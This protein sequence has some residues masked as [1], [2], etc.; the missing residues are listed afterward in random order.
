M[1][2]LG[3][4]NAFVQAAEAE[5]SRS[6]D[7]NSACRRRRSARRWR[8]WR[9]DSSV[10][11]FHRSTR[12]VT[13]TAE[14]RLFLERCRRIFSEVEAA[15]LELSH[16]QAA[17]RG[18]LRVGLPLAGMLMMP[19]IVAFMRAY[20]EITLDLDFSDRVVDVI[21]E[22]FDAVVR[23]AE[24]GDSRLMSRALG[25]IAGA[26]SPP[27]RI[28]RPRAFLGR[29]KTSRVT[30]VCIT[31]FRPAESSSD[32][33]SRPSM[34][35]SRANCP[36]RPWQARSSRSSIWPNKAWASPTCRTSP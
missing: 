31:G 29:R 12:S 25:D 20:P 15:E 33:R 18:T 22:G 11:L 2:S 4:L 3:S 7:G 1:D 26:S 24:A 34:P 13:L 36:G 14:G 27:R 23:F 9:S 19:T 6:P 28:L 8:G 5:A 10:R 32:G 17:P 21:E 30:P 35:G 16:S